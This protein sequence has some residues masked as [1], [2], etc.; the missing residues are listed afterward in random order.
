MSDIRF[1]GTSGDPLIDGLLFDDVVWAGPVVTFQFPT[2]PADYGLPGQYGD[3]G[4]NLD[5]PYNR[6]VPFTADQ[7]AMVREALAHVSELTLLSFE[8]VAPGSGEGVLRF[9]RTGAI[10]DAGFTAWAYTPGTEPEGG[11]VWVSHKTIFDAAFE[12]SLGEA[13]YRVILHE[14][15]HALGLSHP[16]DDA[17]TGVIP[18]AYDG[19]DYTVMS[20][21]SWAGQAFDPDTNRGV[22]A[23]QFGSQPQTFMLLDIQALQ[24]LYGANFETEAGD[25]L[26]SFS[27]ETGE[28]FI[29][30]AGQGLPVTNTI[31]RT[32]WDGDGVD[33]YDL[34][35]YDSNLR[36]DLAPGGWSIFDPAQLARLDSAGHLAPGN[37]A[38]AYLF[39]DDPRSLIENAIGGSGRDLIEG[40]QADNRLDGGDSRDR[41]FGLDGDDT[42]IGGA[43]DDLMR[44][45]SGADTVFGGDGADLA[46][47]DRGEDVMHGEAGDDRLIGSAGADRIY[48][49]L[50]DDQLL[51]GGTGDWIQGGDGADFI[52]GELGHDALFGEE[53]DDSLLGEDG[54]DSV[55][56]G[57][58]ADRVFGDAGSDLL[59]GGSGADRLFGG[60]GADAFVLVDAADSG[61]GA[62]RDVIGDF[63]PDEGDVIDLSAIDADPLAAGDQAFALVAGFSGAG[64]EVRIQETAQPD[65]FVL[66]GDIDG[67]GGADFEILVRGEAPDAGALVL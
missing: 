10:D 65:A 56:G 46:I 38:N 29:D 23:P 8:E 47:G 59:V 36:I 2:D 66:Y 30:G 41:L 18:L 48:G 24:H 45:G 15:G 39:D 51:G 17:G 12:D 44:G 50:G 1:V 28:L 3:T 49:G 21:K 55:Y 67:D 60:A 25:T 52:R 42:L 31:L 4:D 62:A 9:A 32:L 43:G 37:L 53:G 13:G 22:S 35:N 64:G 27:P 6:F 20:Y 11:D 14:L 40:N 61:P 33:T 58:G 63:A 26:Y 16:H 7:Q 34:S 57:A 54:R 5:E 19:L